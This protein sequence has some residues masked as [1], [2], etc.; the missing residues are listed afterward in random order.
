MTMEWIKVKEVLDDNYDGK[1]AELRGWVYRIRKQKNLVFMVLRDSTGTIQCVIKGDNLDKATDLTMESSV[2]VKGTVKKDERAPTGY[3]LS[4]EDLDIVHK[5]ERFP[6]TED[7]STEFLM[8][9]RHLW[10]RSREITHALKIKNTILK[11]GREYFWNN[12]F[13]ETTPPIFV[14]SATEGG[15]TLFE[16]EYFGDKAYLSQSAQLYLEALVFGLDKV[17]AVTPSFRAEKSRTRRH[18]TEY[19]HMEAE[20]AWHDHDDNLKIQ[21][22]LIK[23]IVDAVLE[24]NKEDL[25]ALGR[26]TKILENLELPLPRISYDEAVKIANDK[27]FEV[28]WGDDLGIKEEAA[29]TEEFD[30]P[31]FIEYYP[32]GLKAFYMKKNPDNPKTVKAADMLAP[33]GYGEIIGGSEREVDNKELIKRIKNEGGNPDD[34]DWYLDLRKYG[35]VPHSGFGLGLERLVM[36]ICGLEHIRETT[37]FPRFINRAYP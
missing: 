18:L 37:P 25:E 5:A 29:I 1:E 9:V 21:E 26:D 3:E 30:T 28:E 13:L 33:E 8:D 14:S 22:G 19:S 12:D 24:N 4:V 6:I 10:I 27:G 34:Y 17:F 11:A 36:W 31:F 15:S 32:A 35:S 23:A 16:L 20:M 2:K 7:Q